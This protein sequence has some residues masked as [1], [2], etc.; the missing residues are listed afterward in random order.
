MSDADTT[1]VEVKNADLFKSLRQ[2]TARML[3]YDMAALSPLQ[4]LRLDMVCSLRLEIDRVQGGQLRGEPA[5]LRALTTASE[6]LA[7]LIRPEF[8]STEDKRRED[9]AA[10]AKLGAILHGIIHQRDHEREPIIERLNAALDG[11]RLPEVIGV[12][13][14][15]LR[16]EQVGDP[17]L[18]RVRAALSLP[19]PSLSI[20]A[21]PDPTVEWRVPRRRPSSPP[22]DATDAEI[23]GARDQ[24]N[25]AAVQAAEV[26][27]ARGAETD[28]ERINRINHQ[29]QPPSHYLR[30]GQPR[31][32]WR[33]HVRP[34]WEG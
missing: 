5:D 22:D 7:N 31:E 1:E 8:V 3:S 25:V 33:D 13:L 6:A 12:L 16:H 26:V 17:A 28:A 23:V 19:A 27:S 20:N 18:D 9:E 2:S 24:K 30:D 4:A 14:D 21:P 32:D 11:G 15:L 34:V 10:R 29:S